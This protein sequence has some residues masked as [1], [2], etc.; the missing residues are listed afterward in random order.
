[1]NSKESNREPEN[2]GS[3]VDCKVRV[4]RAH[5][6]R[7]FN[8]RGARIRGT[9]VQGF[10]KDSATEVQ[11]FGADWTRVQPQRCKESRCEV[12]GAFRSSVASQDMSEQGG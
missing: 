3:T 1:L 12:R 11:G 9:E 2:D 7:E 8:H 6:M 4:E 5:E 10:G